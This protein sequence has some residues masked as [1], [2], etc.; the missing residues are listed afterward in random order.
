[1]R[2]RLDEVLAAMAEG[3][4][5]YTQSATGEQRAEV[6]TYVC[7]ICSQVH[8]RSTEDKVDD[9][10]LEHLRECLYDLDLPAG[11]FDH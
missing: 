2:W 9:N 7:P 11:F 6:E 4:L 8:L 10:D 5:F 3:D 1:M